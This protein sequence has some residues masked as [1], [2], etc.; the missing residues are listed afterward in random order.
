MWAVLVAAWTFAIAPRAG[1]AETA[2]RSTMTRLV[3]LGTQGGPRESGE[4]AQP[5]NLLI[6]K[7]IPYLID[8]GNGVVRQLALAHFQPSDI[9]EIFI[10]HNHDD[11][12][13][14]W[15]TLM[16]LAWTNGNTTPITVHGPPGTQSMLTGFLQYFAPNAA[17]HFMEGSHVPPA[18]TM[19]AR[20]INGSGLVFE[21][22]NIRVTAVE[23][24]H[25]H[26]AKGTPGYGWQK[27]FAFRFQTSDRVVVFSGDTGP[28]GHVLA[29]FS[30]DADILV[31]EVIDLAAVEQTLRAN[32]APE[33]FERLM[34]HM[35]TEHSTTEQVG[36]TASEAGV[37]LV[38]L[39]HLVRGRSG[40]TD[41]EFVDGVKK[42]FSGPVVVGQDL[43]EF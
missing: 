36:R 12:D 10:T 43:M 29:D 26:F 1:A 34:N 18:D 22:G 4:R 41:A 7:G 8:A 24:C 32:T 33:R 20:E 6:V 5:S 38:V 15:G 37:H 39:T 35:R 2:A 13:A 28:C 40:A 21:D 11:H 16:G 27:S 14:D 42:F 31:H 3:L 25:Y 23:N 17:A 19:L 9:H 30:R